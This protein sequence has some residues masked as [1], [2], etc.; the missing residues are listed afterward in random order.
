MVTELCI[1]DR[2]SGRTDVERVYDEARMRWL[3]GRPL[4]RALLQAIVTRPW[5]SKLYALGRRSGRSR[6]AIAAFAAEAGIDAA[7]A[8]RPLADYGSIDDFF[9]RRLRPGARPVD[10]D[11]RHL[12][13]PA[14]GRLLVVPRLASGPLPVKRTQV[15]VG[16]LLGDRALARRYVGG[17]GFVVRLAVADYHRFH[18]PDGGA[19]SPSRT[20]AGRLHS[21]HPIALDAAAPAFANQRAVSLLDSDGFGRIALVEVGALTVGTIVQT[22][23]PGRVERG[24][25]KGTFR[26]GGSTLVMLLEPGAVVVDEDLVAASALGAEGAIESR[27][28]MGTRIGARP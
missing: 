21:V 26:M 24:A 11:P 27:V 15:D 17:C 25:E 2:Q 20:I 14:D 7:E 18:F 10:P 23:R 8:E 5:F 28:R 13:C 4:G 19:A 22:Y 16:V 6:A 9:S 1:R 12:V 3:Y